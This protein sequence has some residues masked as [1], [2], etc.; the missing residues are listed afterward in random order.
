MP[1]SNKPRVVPVNK[2]KRTKIIATVG[3]ATESY[4]TIVKLMFQTQ[5]Q[6]HYVTVTQT[7]TAPSTCNNGG[8]GGGGGGFGYG[9]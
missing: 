1:T 9:Y 2:F 7:V 3:P 4:E 6:Q 8:G 5:T